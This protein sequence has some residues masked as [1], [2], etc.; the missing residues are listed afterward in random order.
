M[1]RVHPDAA[2]A[3]GRK[4]DLIPLANVQVLNP[5]SRNKKQH[6]E[7]IDSIKAVGLKRPITV[8]RGVSSGED[9][10]ELICGQGRLEAFVE[11]G[12][13]HIPAFVVEADEDE[14]LV[15][16]L[17][18]NIARRQH[19]PIDLMAE[20]GALHTRGYSDS[21]IAQKIGMSANWVYMVV[22]LLERGEQRLVA[23]VETG[24]IPISLAIEI[25]RAQSS[26]S[27]RLLLEAFE[28]GKIRGKKVGQVRRLLDQRMKRHKGVSDTGFS[29]KNPAKRLSATDLMRLYES[30]T[31]RQRILVKKSD[32]TQA[33]LLFLVVALKDILS[34]EGFC[35]HLKAEGLSKLPKVLASRIGGDAFQ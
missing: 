34:D 12:Q 10:F 32:F 31:Q 16:S 13:D 21:D 9:R 26:E 5:R 27:Q 25:S 23:A 7:I 30:E 14:S 15:M 4:V 35:A 19:R 2:S 29:R 24:L 17:V 3:D 22:S 33:R 1:M 6:Q 20:V 8:R 28:T 18:E 11:L